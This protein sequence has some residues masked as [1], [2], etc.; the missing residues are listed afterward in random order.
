MSF[1]VLGPVL[2]MVSVSYDP[3]EALAPSLII[4]TDTNVLPQTL[5]LGLG[6]DLMNL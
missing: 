3:C 1:P 2:A 6:L 4:P 5:G